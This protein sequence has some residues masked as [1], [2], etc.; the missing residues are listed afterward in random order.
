[1][2][3]YCTR[4]GAAN[5]PI[6]RH[7]GDCGA[8]LDESP[9]AETPEREP[10]GE[11]PAE[12]VVRCVRCGAPVHD[13]PICHICG[14]HQPLPPETSDPFLILTLGQFP[15]LLRAPRE[16]VRE[17]P[18]YNDLRGVVLPLLGLSL[19]LLIGLTTATVAGWPPVA[20]ILHTRALNGD[21]LI[22]LIVGMTL[23]GPLAFF[24][25]AAVIQAA[26]LMLGGSGSLE[27]TLRVLALLWI[28]LVIMLGT[29]WGYYLST[30]PAVEPLFEGAIPAEQTFLRYVLFYIFVLL[31]GITYVF[32][33]YLV[34]LATWIDWG[35]S[36]LI[37]FGLL[38]LVWAGYA[39][40]H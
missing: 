6:A 5:P 38:L 23:L 26:A 8:L 35:R 3:Q 36:L 32:Q 27:R 20:L 17:L 9:T 37:H 15:L 4:C 30:Q 12:E 24:G 22:S 16:T 25:Y 10:S 29:V 14:T 34:A 39:L 2:L 13:A 40:T 1:M 19:A 7:C 11:T 18:Y 33:S 31:A 28:P 21:G